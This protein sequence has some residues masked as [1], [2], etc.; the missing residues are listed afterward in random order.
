MRVI[1]REFR[2][3]TMTQLLVVC[4][5]CEQVIVGVYGVL[6]REVFD[7]DEDASYWSYAT[8]VSEKALRILCKV[9]S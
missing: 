5:K 9:E 8:E 4:H 1:D 7:G 3:M 6:P 2:R